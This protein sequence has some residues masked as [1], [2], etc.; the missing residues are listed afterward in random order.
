MRPPTI[1]PR[2]KSTSGAI[3]GLKLRVLVKSVLTLMIGAFKVFVLMV[4]ALRKFVL[5][6]E[7]L[8][9]GAFKVVVLIVE[10]IILETFR[11]RG[12]KTSAVDEMLIARF[13]K[14]LTVAPPTNIS[15]PPFTGAVVMVPPLPG[16][17]LNCGNIA[18]EG[19]SPGAT[20]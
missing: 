18:K 10:P 1:P 19:G 17:P 15:K 4:E 8:M 2:P 11:E 9:R 6:V 5:M 12:I 20:A 14:L 7:A 3:V 13:V 16:T